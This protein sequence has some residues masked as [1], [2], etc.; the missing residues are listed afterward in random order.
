MQKIQVL[1]HYDLTV[2]TETNMRAFHLEAIHFGEIITLRYMKLLGYCR[3]QYLI[4]GNKN[5]IKTI[6]INKILFQSET[7]SYGE[8]LFHVKQL[9]V[10]GAIAIGGGKH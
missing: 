9:T 8:T 5:N 1:T 4:L 7:L 2:S 3:D 6:S 10:G